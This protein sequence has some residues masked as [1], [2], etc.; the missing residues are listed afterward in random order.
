MRGTYAEYRGA[1]LRLFPND[2]LNAPPNRLCRS[3]SPAGL[4]ASTLRF[5]ACAFG[6]SVPV[7]E[8]S[9]ECVE[10]AEAEGGGFLV[11]FVERRRLVV[12]VSP[13]VYR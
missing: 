7:A 11:D 13:C 3:L 8:P 1:G 12:L 9:L 6:L 4:L 5:L 2:P 10:A